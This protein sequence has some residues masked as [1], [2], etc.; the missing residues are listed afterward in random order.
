MSNL[1]SFENA[2]ENKY[3]LI[4]RFYIPSD[5]R[6]QYVE[7]KCKLYSTYPI[8]MLN[9]DYNRTVNPQHLGGAHNVVT[10]RAF[11]NHNGDIVRES[12][13]CISVKHVGGY[14]KGEPLIVEAKGILQYILGLGTR[15][16]WWKAPETYKLAIVLPEHNPM[17][18]ILIEKGK[19]Y[20]KLMNQRV[21]K[22]NLLYSVSRYL[23][24]ACSEKDGVKLLTYLMGM[25]ELPEN[26]TYVLENRLPYFFFDMST[27][28]KVDCRLNTQLI[29]TSEVA[30]EVSD[31]IW[32]SLEVSD[33]DT[34]INTFYLGHKRS[35]RWKN[36]S[37]RTL[38]TRCMGE[39]PT[40]AQLDLMKEFLVQNRTKDLVENRAKELMESLV[41]KYPDRINL[42]DVKDG[43][44]SKKVMLVSGKMCDWAL[45]DRRN[46]SATQKVAVYVWKASENKWSGSICID[47]IHSNSSLGDQFAAR[48]L[49]LLN[50]SLTVKLVHTISRHIDEDVLS[51]EKE[52]RYPIPIPEIDEE[53]YNWREHL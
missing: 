26:I 48:A 13:I 31:G 32:G 1:D 2:Y 21:K 43:E 25:L 52:S 44:I 47:N 8:N 5:D 37:P 30:I 41:V 14:H 16:G 49:A 17:G 3:N 36:C 15:R 24:R 40:D 50:D 33:L 22:N 19:T 4:V 38:W 7:T 28:A 51:G 18:V 20:Y 6:T 10:N 53:T 23:F 27:R 29:G 34:M 42:F 35:S 11:P 12:T 46:S 39:E 45:F 9:S